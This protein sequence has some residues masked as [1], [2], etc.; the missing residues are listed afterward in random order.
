MAKKK[1]KKKKPVRK[2]SPKK[3]VKKRATKRARKSSGKAVRKR[4]TS[5]RKKTALVSRRASLGAQ[6][7]RLRRKKQTA[8]IAYV[9]AGD[10][11]IKFTEQLVLRLAEAGADVIELGVPFSDPIADGPVIQRASE[12]ALQAGTS[13][14]DVL[15]LAGRIRR[16]SSVP[17]VLFS[18]FNPVLQM[19]II[20]FAERAS[21]AGVDGVLITD[22][23]PEEAE[24]FV[25]VMRRHK[26]DTVFLAAP[27]STP[28]RL[29]EIARLSR[30][31]VYVIARRGV[32][33]KR[34]DVPAE[35]KGQLSRLRK[36]T[37]LPLAVGFGV[38]K[39]KHVKQLEKAA[40]GVVVGS[41]LVE[42]CER[43]GH[44]EKALEAVGA[45]VRELKG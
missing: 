27:T 33:G 22:L 10:P 42:C 26:L 1:I 12:R 6:L 31:F 9:T 25:A 16:K 29:K 8:F 43:H 20:R 2:K 14:A 38:S 35:V 34:S 32:T 17:M 15:K 11:T 21:A 41:A 44:K 45:L 23:I 39:R 13:L 5:S 30:G 7:G 28:A 24:E 36:V 18:Y 40:D 3:A 37:K 19:G 4:K